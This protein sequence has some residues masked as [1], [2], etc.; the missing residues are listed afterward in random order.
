MLALAYVDPK[1]SGDGMRVALR[2]LGLNLLKLSEMTGIPRETVRRRLKSLIDLGL[3]ATGRERTY[4]LT[5]KAAFL[6][7]ILSNLTHACGPGVRA[8][9]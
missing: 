6:K 8:A 2:P 1:W 4:L 3:V 9:I 7:G 5:G